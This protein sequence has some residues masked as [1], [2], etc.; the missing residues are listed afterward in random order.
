MCFWFQPPCLCEMWSRWTDDFCMCSSHREARRRRCGGALL[1]T[2]SVIYLEFKAHLTSMATTAFCSDTP[3]QS[4]LRLVGLSFV[5]NRT[6]TQH[7]CRLCKGYL[8]RRRVMEWPGLGWVGPQSE[9]KQPKSAQHMCELLQ[10]CWV[11]IPGDAGWEN[12]KSVQ[13]CHQGKWWLFEESKIYFDLL[14][15]F[16]GYYMIPC[17][18]FTDVFTIVL[19]CG[20]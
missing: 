6:M 8:T 12:A 1:V 11:S 15:T 14:N 10:D 7:P 4:G 5:F 19:Q 3:F 17:V 18:I 20:K 9:R 16:F 2:L 13:S